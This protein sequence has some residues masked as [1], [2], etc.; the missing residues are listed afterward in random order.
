[1]GLQHGFDSMRDTLLGS[2]N[3]ACT[4]LFKKPPLLLRHL[5]LQ[6]LGYS[7]HMSHACKKNYFALKLQT[8]HLAY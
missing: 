5:S 8:R 4:F 7:T 6:T 3:G 1:M 2:A